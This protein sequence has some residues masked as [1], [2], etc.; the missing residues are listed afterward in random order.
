MSKGKKWNSDAIE[1]GKKTRRGLR[2]TARVLKELIDLP[3]HLR[4][5]VYPSS[6]FIVL[7]AHD[8]RNGDTVVETAREYRAAFLKAFGRWSDELVEVGHYYGAQWCATWSG[9]RGDVQ[10][11]FKIYCT[12]QE[13]EE[14][15]LLK[16]GCEIVER[17]EHTEAAEA[18]DTTTLTVECSK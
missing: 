11:R 15:N 8:S 18:Y 3:F 6:N 1:I 17:T 16:E 14:E 4:D 9:E 13:V 10:V 5:V 12:R 7:H 2:N